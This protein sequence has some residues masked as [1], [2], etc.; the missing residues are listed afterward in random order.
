MRLIIKF[1]CAALLASAAPAHALL[2]DRGNEY[3][4]SCEPL[5]CGAW[6]VQFQAGI[7]P[8]LWRNRGDFTVINCL[9]TPV[10]SSGVQIPKFSKLFHLPWQVGGQLSYALSANSNI[11]TEVNYV[12]AKAKSTLPSL[13]PASLALSGS[14]KYKLVEWYVGARY[15]FDR[16][17]CWCYFD[18]LSVFLGG[19]L[20]LVHHKGS[21]GFEVTSSICGLCFPN[22]NPCCNNSGSLIARNTAFAGGGQIGLDYCICGNWSLVFCAEVVATC[23]PA[24][25]GAN[26][27]GTTLNSLIIGGSGTELAFPITLGVKY[28]F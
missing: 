18:G 10:V 27:L 8:I 2:F 19:K 12:Q 11:F 28:N 23:G 20:G 13:A 1:L 5:Y 3:E 25:C 4:C 17:G 15:Y 22:A 21:S 6:G 7:R 24:N 9:A 26:Q 16:G 14:S